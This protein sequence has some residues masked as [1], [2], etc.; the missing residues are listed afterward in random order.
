[1]WCPS[2]DDLPHRREAAVRLHLNSPVVAQD[3]PEEDQRLGPHNLPRIRRHETTGCLIDGLYRK[4]LI[5]V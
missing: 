1:M 2:I 3:I 5:L 4:I